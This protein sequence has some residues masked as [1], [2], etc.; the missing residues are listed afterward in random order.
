MMRRG[1]VR[2]AD[3]PG[4]RPEVRPSGPSGPGW[5]ADRRRAN[6]GEVRPSDRR[7]IVT[8]RVSLRDHA[9]RAGGGRREDQSVDEGQQAVAVHP[10]DLERIG[11]AER[12]LGRRPRLGDDVEEPPREGSRAIWKGEAVSPTPWASVTVWSTTGFRGSSMPRTVMVLLKLLALVEPG[13]AGVRDQPADPD[14]GIPRAGDRPDELRASPCSG[15]SRRRRSSDPGRTRR[16]GPRPSGGS[17][18]RAGWGPGRGC[19]P[20]GS[21]WPGSAWSRRSRSARWG[22]AVGFDPE[23]E[24][25]WRRR[26]PSRSTTPAPGSGRGSW[27]PRPPLTRTPSGLASTAEMGVSLPW[28]ADA[29]GREVRPPEGGVEPRPA[30]VVVL[31]R[32]RQDIPRQPHAHGIGPSRGEG[33]PRDVRQPPI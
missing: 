9:L 29:E 23:A 3:G 28:R 24:E 14:E 21:R 4:L 15:R 33:R 26:P 20:W 16:R 18:A 22:A 27:G 25:V 30:Q 32:D 6:G 17:G 8:A 12:V 19:P 5:A 10:Q 7:P 13:P 11:V 1:A 31:V 2:R